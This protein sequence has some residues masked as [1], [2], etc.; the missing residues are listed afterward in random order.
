MPTKTTLRDLLK[1]YPMNELWYILLKDREYIGSPIRA[2]LHYDTLVDVREKLLN[3]PI[4]ENPKG[5]LNC[6]LRI[7]EDELI[8][9]FCNIGFDPTI[10]TFKPDTEGDAKFALDFIDWGELI[11]CEVN[12]EHLERYGGLVVCAE[13]LNELT[14]HTHDNYADSGKPNLEERMENY[15]ENCDNEDFIA[16][17]EEFEREMQADL[18]AYDEELNE[19]SD[20]TEKWLLSAP[21][22]VKKR[23]VELHLYRSST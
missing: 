17:N 14:W 5:I 13:L 16:D 22:A 9:N 6:E 11:D 12:D 2:E 1:K 8:N 7:D 21:T 10:T 15:L 4:D 3:L 18:K 20:V 19:L 23:I